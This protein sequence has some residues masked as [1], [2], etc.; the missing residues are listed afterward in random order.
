MKKS[1]KLEE[2]LF[3][4]LTLVIAKAFAF[5]ALAFICAFVLACFWIVAA[6]F[7]AGR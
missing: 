3:M 7:S 2:L 4:A 1:D 6:L 5:A